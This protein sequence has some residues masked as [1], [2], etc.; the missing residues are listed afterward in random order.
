M[1]IRTNI[2]SLAPRR[3]QFKREIKLLSRGYKNPVA[4]PDGRITVYPWDNEIDDWIVANVRKL[5]TEELAYGLLARCCDL[6]GGRIDDFIAD[7]TNLVLLVSK[8]NLGAERVQYESTCPYCNY[9]T[10]ESIRIP[11]ELEP[12]GVKTADYVGYDIVTLA[13]A[14]DV[15]KLRPLTIA[16]ERHISGDTRSE[17]DRRLLS[18]ATLRIISRVVEINDSKPDRLDELV[19]WYRALSPGDARFLDS[20]GKRITPHLNTAVPHRCDKC[21][22]DFKHVLDFSQE[23]FR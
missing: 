20:E 7:E 22:K 1:A 5:P 3:E 17:T 14:G 19:T 21:N 11:D 2:K 15:V 18:D 13:D 8:A 16:D 9:T 4:W 10:K 6:N 23:F 12:V